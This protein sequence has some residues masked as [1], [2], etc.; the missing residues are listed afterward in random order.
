[1]GEQRQNKFDWQ[2]ESYDDGSEKQ[3]AT[4]A[5]PIFPIRLHIIQKFN[6]FQTDI[7]QQPKLIEMFLRAVLGISA[8]LPKII[9]N[10]SSRDWLIF[11][12][13]IGS[14]VSPC[15]PLMILLYSGEHLT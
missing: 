4:A 2:T 11:S 9:T 10:Q 13:I 5:V 1:M 12:F 14:L 7:E 8:F 6:Y 3:P 15:D